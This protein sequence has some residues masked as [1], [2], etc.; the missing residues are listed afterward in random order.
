[1]RKLDVEKGFSGLE[2]EKTQQDQIPE[3]DRD[4]QKERKKGR[5]EGNAASSRRVKPKKKE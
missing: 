3:K 5:F 1:M 2:L 4:E